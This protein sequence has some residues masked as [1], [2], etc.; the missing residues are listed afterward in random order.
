MTVSVRVRKAKQG[1]YHNQRSRTPSHPVAPH[2]GP[3]RFPLPPT[4][5]SRAS[6]TRPTRDT[7][8]PPSPVTEA[9]ARKTTGP[10][11]CSTRLL[12]NRGWRLWE[13]LVW[14]EGYRMIGR[15]GGGFSERE[16]TQDRRCG[17]EVLVPWALRCASIP[18][19]SLTEGDLSLLHR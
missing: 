15:R 10:G 5:R 8:K 14:L 9:P 2:H 6:R 13:H 19:G 12:G 1:T 3:T 18:C 17:L 11:R 4:H 16:R 7:W